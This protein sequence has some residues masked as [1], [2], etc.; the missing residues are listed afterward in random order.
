MGVAADSTRQ[1][2]ID[3]MADLEKQIEV[4]KESVKT[5]LAMEKSKNI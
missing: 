5:L 2:I 1:A 4:A 3:T